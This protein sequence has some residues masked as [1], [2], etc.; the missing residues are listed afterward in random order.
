MQTLVEITNKAIADYGFR[1]AVLWS[2]DDVAE[3]RGL[4][5]SEAAALKG[6]VRDALEEL[7]IPVEP[8]DQPAEESRFAKIIAE[9]LR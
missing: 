6:P 2:P 3:Q 7:P 5:E 9:A 4:S 8:E 1:Q